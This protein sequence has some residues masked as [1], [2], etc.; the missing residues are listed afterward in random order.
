VRPQA[1]RLQRARASRVRQTA[2][3]QT[4]FLQDA[5]LCSPLRLSFLVVFSLL[6]YFH[7]THHCRA[8][9]YLVTDISVFDSWRSTPRLATLARIIFFPNSKA[10]SVFLSFSFLSLINQLHSTHQKN[11]RHGVRERE[12]SLRRLVLHQILP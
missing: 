11:V 2:S 1:P 4:T 3:Q 12:R 6:N 7:F 10:N 9:S 8:R 5:L